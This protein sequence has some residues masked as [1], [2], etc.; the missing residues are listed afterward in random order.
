MVTSICD[1]RSY[2]VRVHQKIHKGQKV[3][4]TLSGQALLTQGAGRESGALWWGKCTNEY[5]SPR[6]SGVPHPS[7]EHDFLL[8][9]LLDWV[10]ASPERLSAVI[11]S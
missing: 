4:G 10:R 1:V 6:S 8:Q 11:C 2:L 5:A 9:C 7:F 3:L